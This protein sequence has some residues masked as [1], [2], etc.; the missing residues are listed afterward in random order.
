MGVAAASAAEEG[1]AALARSECRIAV[2][3]QAQAAVVNPKPIKV[4]R[5][6]R[7]RLACGGGPPLP[8]KSLLDRLLNKTSLPNSLAAPGPATAAGRPLLLYSAGVAGVAPIAT[9]L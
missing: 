8:V 3:T 7:G 2:E 1:A 6:R 4:C 5:S 9:S